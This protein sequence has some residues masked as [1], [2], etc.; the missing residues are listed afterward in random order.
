MERLSRLAGSLIREPFRRLAAL[1]HAAALHPH[2]LTFKAELVSVA[3]L[4]DGRYD[5]IARL[6]KGAGTP[7]GRADVLGLAFRVIRDG[8]PWDFLMSTAGQ[9]RLTRWLPIPAGDWG[10]ACY[11]MLSPYERHGRQF[12]LRATPSASV[13]HASVDGLERRAPAAFVLATADK[14]GD[15]LTIGHLKLLSAMDGTGDRF[16][17]VLNCPPGWSLAPAWLRTIR[18]LAYQGSRRGRGHAPA[19]GSA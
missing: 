11:G 12:W 10:G 1:R 2:G 6:T 17:P 14:S 8:R 7:N 13:G 5:A 19:K 15:W 3:P 18:E 16:D 4:P 9:G